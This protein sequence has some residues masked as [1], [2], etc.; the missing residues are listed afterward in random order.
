MTS[1]K[2]KLM[3]IVRHLFPDN[4]ACNRNNWDLCE[5]CCSCL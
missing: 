4:W 5:K 1:V 2:L 3:I